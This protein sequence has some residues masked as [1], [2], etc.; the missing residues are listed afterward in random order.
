[1]TVTCPHCATSIDVSA[2]YA[3]I[4]GRCPSCGAVMTAPGIRT[5]SASGRV[6]RIA[7]A[8]RTL[9]H[10]APICLAVIHL[11]VVLALGPLVIATFNTESAPLGLQ[12]LAIIDYPVF[13][14]LDQTIA[15][16]RSFV[17]W[18]IVG[19]SFFGGTLQWYFV[20]RLPLLACRLAC[21]ER[22]ASASR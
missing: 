14:L 1:M 5:L 3:G 21:G 15:V 8:W 18:A 16:D 19:V 20:G 11:L 17:P 10:P 13:W 9:L 2:E 6:R 12:T 22:E 7:P 4:C